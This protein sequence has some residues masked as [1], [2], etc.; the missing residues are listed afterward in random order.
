MDHPFFMSINT[1][2]EDDRA[3]FRYRS[4]PEVILIVVIVLQRVLLIGI[5]ISRFVFV[6]KEFKSA[7]SWFEAGWPELEPSNRSKR[8]CHRAIYRTRGSATGRFQNTGTNCAR[9]VTSH[10]DIIKRRVNARYRKWSGTPERFIR[11]EN[12]YKTYSGIS[13]PAARTQSRAREKSKSDDRA[14]YTCDCPYIS[15][16]WWSYLLIASVKIHK[17]LLTTM[18]S[19]FKPDSVRT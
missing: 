6:H 10:R 16:D 15:C 14:N 11:N 4:D 12:M 3:T 7:V 17:N 5:P 8:P 2:G 9:C 13:S 18:R 1:V 19:S